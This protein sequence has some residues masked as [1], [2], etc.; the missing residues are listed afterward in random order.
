M[1]GGGGAGMLALSDLMIAFIK[2]TSD[3]YCYKNHCACL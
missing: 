2:L 1:C 3:D